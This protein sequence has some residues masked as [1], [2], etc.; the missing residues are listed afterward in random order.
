MFSSMTGSMG[1]VVFYNFRLYDMLL[2]RVLWQ[3]FFN[4]LRE[5]ITRI[6]SVRNRLGKISKNQ[7]L[8]R[9]RKCGFSTTEDDKLMQQVRHFLCPSPSYLLQE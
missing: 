6:I 2:I 3:I 5:K 8:K 1:E 7:L 4:A 9:L